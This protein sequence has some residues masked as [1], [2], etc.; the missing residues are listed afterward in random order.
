MK[1]EN[2]QERGISNL[3]YL[4]LSAILNNNF[5][6]YSHFRC[7]ICTCRASYQFH[8]SLANQDRPRTICP[9]SRT[10]RTARKNMKTCL[11][12]KSFE[13]S[14]APLNEIDNRSP[15]CL[16]N[17][18]NLE[19]VFKSFPILRNSPSGK[20]FKS[21]HGDI[22]FWRTNISI[23]KS[24]NAKFTDESNDQVVLS[25]TSLLAME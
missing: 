20:F 16:L 12:T 14:C 15:D 21:L 9:I 25:T 24:L 7:W 17:V 11:K 22:V 4:I 1:Y 19:S 23:I 6:P 3:L 18:K 13:I 8:V 10:P 2:F 5:I